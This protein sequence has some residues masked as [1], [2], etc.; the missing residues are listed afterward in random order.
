LHA[1]HPAPVA[2]HAPAGALAC[3]YEHGVVVVPAQVL[4]IAGDY[5]LDTGTPH[6]TV[7]DTQAQ[8]AG[9]EGAGQ[10]GEVRLGA[11]TLQ[12]RPVVV[13]A[14]DMRTGALPTPVAGVIGADVLK[15]YVVD[16]RFAPCRIALYAPGEAPPLRR[17]RRLPMRWSGEVPAVTAAVADGPHAL[18]GD[19]VLA[20]GADI[21][22]RI[23]D[24]AASAPGARK[25]K[26]LYPGGAL[27]PSLRALS[28][29][30]TLWENTPSGLLKAADNPALG[31]LGATLL[32]PY[33]LRFDFPR[34]QLSVA[35]GGPPPWKAHEKGPPDRSGGP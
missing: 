35:G 1:I 24:A 28:F 19:F 23:S 3:W 20:T 33:R 29:A 8:A 14:L 16:V 21:P 13:A 10:I 26:E 15:A 27:W 11:V 4:G 6:T 34:M 22:V 31:Q 7:A 32:S 25:P 9:Y 12:D 18:S 17:A 2:A 30:G 5:I